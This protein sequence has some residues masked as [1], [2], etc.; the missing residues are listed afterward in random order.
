[1]WPSEHKSLKCSKYR[2][3]SIKYELQQSGMSDAKIEAD[4]LQQNLDN[5]TSHLDDNTFY[6]FTTAIG[7]SDRDGNCMMDNWH[8]L[9][10]NITQYIPQQFRIVFHHFYMA[11]DFSPM[12][13]T[14]NEKIKLMIEDEDICEE[15]YT[16]LNWEF[17]DSLFPQNE[18]TFQEM[19]GVS[20]ETILN[21]HILIDMAHL[22]G[23]A[24]RNHFQNDPQ[25]GGYD[26]M[27][28]NKINYIYLGYDVFMKGIPEDFPPLLVFN[29]D[30]LLK[31]AY[32]TSNITG[33]LMAQPYGVFLANEEPE[34]EY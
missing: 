2:S 15:E 27:F 1:M 30:Q 20:L 12:S 5:N 25:Y 29:N 23:Y 19:V 13:L 8:T 33:I 24:K 34:H 32:R 22:V 7:Y 10:R 17:H 31:Y 21:R 4:I 18:R 16:V 6:I 11:D 28:L 26:I 3:T 9:L 14:W